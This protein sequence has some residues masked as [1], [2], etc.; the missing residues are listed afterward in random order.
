MTRVYYK[1]AAGALVVFDMSRTSTFDGALR[2]KTDL[3]QKLTLL[4][5]RPIPAVLCAN[6]VRQ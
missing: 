2:W 4:D 3:D 6:K 5:G 1:E